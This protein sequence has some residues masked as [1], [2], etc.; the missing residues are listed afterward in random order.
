MNNISN[1]RTENDPQL[2]ENLVGTPSLP[3]SLPFP[4]PTP[5][6]SFSCSFFLLPLHPLFVFIPTLTSPAL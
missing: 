6:L 1:M 4:L 5:H 3:P 2:V